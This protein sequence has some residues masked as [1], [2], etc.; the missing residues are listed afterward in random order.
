MK[1]YLLFA[2]LLLSLTAC[3]Q[4]LDVNPHSFTSGDKYY[5]TEDQVLKAVNGAY[6]QLQGLY[7]GDLY[8]MAE[9]RSDNT[10]YQFNES[11]RGVQQ[12]E[13]IDE[14][15]INSSNN[16]VQNVWAALYKGVMQS[17][18]ILS[19]ID[20][21]PF[22]DESL[23][24]QYVGEAKFLRAVHYF[25]LVRLF[26]S[27]PLITKEIAGPEQA[28]TAEK[29][30]V[31]NIYQQIISDVQDAVNQ[32]PQTYTGQNVGRAT[33]G[34]AHTLLG[35]VYLTR[36]DYAKAI[37]SFEQVKGY[38]LVSDYASVFATTNKNHS[39]SV[40]EVQYNAD[41]EGESSNF[42]Y[43]FGPYN[44]GVPLTT[45]QGN[46]GGMNIPTR[47]IFQTYEKGDKRRDASIGYYIDAGND[48]Y[49]EAFGQDS[50]PYIKKF[51]HPPFKLQGRTDDNWPVYR[52][53][54][55]MLMLAEALNE[56]G[57]TAAA[58]QYLNPVRQRAGLAPLAGLSQTA[59][60]EA[61]YHE[62]RVEVAFENHRWFDLLRTGRAQTVMNAH[63]VEEKKRLPRLSAAAFNVQDYMLL[64]PIP[65]REIR[66]NGFEQN[67]GW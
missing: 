26:G 6:G 20:A 60:R 41:M 7:T 58:Y 30:S 66:L 42:I 50:L 62:Q 3:Q 10:T 22:K 11:D 8:A 15:L 28:F 2:A 48:K 46:L 55:V 57:Q 65:Q 47:N 38:T 35:H 33:K 40:F 39:E 53:S 14:F 59:F 5:S 13:E 16:Y 29:A 37:A 61:V 4:A 63:G 27:V 45:F 44:A 24:A 1:T 51:F 17:N 19:R 49:S 12:R 32:L 56:T 64:Y 36:K 34:A 18:V 54:H 52:Y 21:V 23:K 25:Y 43:S 31:D 9:M 67:P